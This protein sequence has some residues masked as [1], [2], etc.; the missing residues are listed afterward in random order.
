MPC[1]GFRRTRRWCCKT[2]G[3]RLAP[4]PFAQNGITAF[5]DLNSI[6]LAAIRQIDILRDGASPIY[7]SDAIAGVVNIR[8][9]EK[10]NGALVSAG[11]GNTTDTDTA[12]YRASIVSGCSDERRGIEAVLVA[13]YFHR[14]A[15]FQSD[16][17]FS[18]SIDQ[19]RLGGRSFLSSVANPGTVFDPITGDPLRVPADSNGR[20]AVSDFTEGRNRFDRA[21]FQPLVP[22]TERAGV[23]HSVAPRHHHARR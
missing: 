16:R 23:Y 2:D 5:V 15:L 12:E 3:R 7:G 20:P 1:G 19:T 13:D 9:V 18:E 4:Y 17:Y 8:F 6:P 10:F 22:E 14:N 21:P 11:Y